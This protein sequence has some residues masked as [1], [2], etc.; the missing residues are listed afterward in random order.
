VLALRERI[1]PRDAEL[2][3]AEE[4]LDLDYVPGCRS[5]WPDADSAEHLIAYQLFWLRRHN[6]VI[7][8]TGG[9]SVPGEDNGRD[10]GRTADERRSCNTAGPAERIEQLCDSGS[11]QSIRSAVRSRHTAWTPPR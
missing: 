6:A 9:N 3:T 7:C 8:I 10:R 5:H 1:A 11:I 2:R 4:G